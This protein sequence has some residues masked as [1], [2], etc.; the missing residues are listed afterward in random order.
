M[1]FLL[2]KSQTTTSSL[3]AMPLARGVCSTRTTR[4]VE[5]ERAEANEKRY[6]G[7]GDATRY[8]DQHGDWT[9]NWTN[10]QRVG[11]KIG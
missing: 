6:R 4:G 9:N 11:L 2:G 3:P 5:Q 8:I 7:A 1:F 10:K